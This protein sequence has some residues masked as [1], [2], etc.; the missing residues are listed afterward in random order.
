MG[1]RKK[2]NRENNNIEAEKVH[3]KL[4]KVNMEAAGE[5]QVEDAKKQAGAGNPK[6]QKR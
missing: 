1:K 3:R 6:N 4:E 2:L 5:F